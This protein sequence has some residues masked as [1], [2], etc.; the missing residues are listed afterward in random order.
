VKEPTAELRI[1]R[2]DDVALRVA[3]HDASVRFYTETLGFQLEAEWTLVDAFPE[4]RL[5]NVRLAASCSRSSAT[6]G[7]MSRRP[8]PTSPTTWAAVASISACAWR[9]STPP[10]QSYAAA[11]SDLRRAVRG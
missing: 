5:A 8:R 7:P 4:L 2:A 6:P 1:T 10:W 11:V 9:L 3:D